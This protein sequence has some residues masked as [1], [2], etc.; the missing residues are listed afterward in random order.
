MIWVFLIQ[1]IADLPV[2]CKSTDMAGSW[3]F[4]V[5]QTVPDMSNDNVMKYC[6]GSVP[7]HNYA[8][9]KQTPALY[10][11]LW[12]QMD[13]NLKHVH[14]ENNIFI[15][16]AGTSVGDWTP[17]YDEGFQVRIPHPDKE[18][19]TRT[20]FAFNRYECEPN[21]PHCGN[22]EDG[23]TSTGKTPGYVSLCGQTGI[24][25]VRDVKDSTKDVVG[26]GCFV[27][28]KK[29]Q[30]DLVYNY[31][32]PTSG[33]VPNGAI[34]KVVTKQKKMS[35]TVYPSKYFEPGASTAEMEYHPHI[36]A[37]LASRPV[38]EACNADN[39]PGVI[40]PHLRGSSF[41]SIPRSHVDAFDWREHSSLGSPVT[42]QGQCGSCY[43]IAS[44]SALEFGFNIA[45]K[46][47][48][49]PETVSLSQQSALACNE[50]TQGCQGGFPF[51]TMKKFSQDGVPLASCQEYAASD[52]CKSD[53]YNDPSSLAYVSS[54]GYVGGSY[55]RC[56]E[57]EIQQE[58]YRHGP[59]T[60]AFEVPKSFGQ[61]S[62]VLASAKHHK[63]K[64]DEDIVE[65][66]YTIGPGSSTSLVELD[67]AAFSRLAH[68]LDPY[69][70]LP[71]EMV[72]GKVLVHG[73][74]L[75]EGFTDLFKTCVVQSR[76]ASFLQT[77]SG[78]KESQV[79]I[80]SLVDKGIN[81]WE[82]TNHAVV[83]FGWGN[84]P[85]SLSQTSQSSKFLGF[86]EQTEV[87]KPFWVVR[88]SWGKGF[89]RKG[90]AY[91][92]RGVDGNGIESQAVFGRP[93]FTRGLGASLLQKYG[94]TIE[95]YHKVVNDPYRHLKSVGDT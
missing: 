68:C 63:D 78:F 64:A 1:V 89:D 27:G 69:V 18:G 48:G 82:Y 54:Y 9:L 37:S 80:I 32:R 91:L 13:V 42:E 8:N 58:V 34:R 7:N 6:M 60:A 39:K 84:Q 10:A 21:N 67:Q 87:A 14:D 52:K 77:P 66:Q 4:F 16:E 36:G 25:F 20:F 76:P 53:C 28:R 56:S 45:L 81:D 65:V 57:K 73:S 75:D 47:M 92:E 35:Y 24:G 44:T 29:E 62:V 72:S 15:A 79:K 51:L 59:V 93:D 50:Y 86:G 61:A 74:R 19:V 85:S 43:A 12:N 3:T 2:H 70:V 23:E 41:A 26:K 22:D 46:A 38:V 31:V 55:G 49:I 83:I 11:S 33:Y 17:I 95:D 40:S 5:S 88:N 90:Y 94:K 30:H 71:Q